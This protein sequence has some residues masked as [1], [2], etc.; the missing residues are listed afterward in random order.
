MKLRELKGAVGA[1]KAFA[2]LSNSLETAAEAVNNAA[3]IGNAIACNTLMKRYN[4]PYDYRI[5][6]ENITQT[7][8]KSFN[9]NFTLAYSQGELAKAVMWCEDLIKKLR[10]NP[11]NLSKLQAEALIAVYKN[12]VLDIGREIRDS[13]HA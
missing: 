12:L 13:T 2:K 8:S 3:L 9:P 7:V 4:A 6:A 10:K 5:M 1:A 11:Q